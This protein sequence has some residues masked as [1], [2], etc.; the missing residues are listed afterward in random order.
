[1]SVFLDDK[2]ERVTLY[3]D[4][5]FKTAGDDENYS[6]TLAK[7]L[8]RIKQVEV[9]SVEIP[10]SFYVFTANNNV[11]KFNDE[12]ST[13]QTATITPGN[14]SGT[15]ISVELETQLNAASSGGWTVTYNSSTYK[16]SMSRT[17]NFQLFTT[18]STIASTI[19]LLA[20]SPVTTSHGFTGIANLS[21]PN[22]I[23]I[24]SV[25]L[26]RPKKILPIENSNATSDILYKLAL[27][28]G[29]GTT[30]T[31]RN[32]F[33]T[34]LTYAVRQRMQT[35]DFRLEDLDGNQLDLNGLNW[36]IT[37]ILDIV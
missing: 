14:Y 3:F 1:M 18:D 21:G 22:Y 26:T 33:P 27:Q 2:F 16:L 17:S 15:T 35:L 4:S 23:Y 25:A 5:K 12:N 37:I 36:S 8:N 34:K 13:L 7:P 20:D 10:Y 19:G 31:E 28:T 6:I 24:R 30:I 32:L 11:L 9:V 29:P